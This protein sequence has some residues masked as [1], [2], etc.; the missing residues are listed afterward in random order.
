M[1]SFVLLSSGCSDL[2]CDDNGSSNVVNGTNVTNTTNKSVVAPVSNAT[3]SPIASD[4]NGVYSSQLCCG[5]GIIMGG[6]AWSKDEDSL[7]AYLRPIKRDFGDIWIGI[8]LEQNGDDDFRDM[9]RMA[10]VINDEGF[11]IMGIITADKDSLP[12][13]ADQVSDRYNFIDAWCLGYNGNLGFDGD[14]TR[15]GEAATKIKNNNKNSI[16]IID[17]PSMCEGDY[18]KILQ[19]KDGLNNVDV[20]GIPLESRRD[21]DSLKTSMDRAEKPVWCTGLWISSSDEDYSSAEYQAESWEYAFSELQGV[22]GMGI[23]FVPDTG[24]EYRY[25]LYGQNA[26][27]RPSYQVFQDYNQKCKTC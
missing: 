1:I 18:E 3:V 13:F 21:V 2:I 19:Y 16:V 12:D 26:L 10:G 7:R 27:K 14:T 5:Y 4:P 22:E 15:A 11:R 20:I 25:G 24:D 6:S 17:G 8:D 9:D 23:I